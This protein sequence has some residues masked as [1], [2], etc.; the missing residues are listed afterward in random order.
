MIEGYPH[1]T[2]PMWRGEETFVELILFFHHRLQGVR[3]KSSGRLG[4]KH[5]LPEPS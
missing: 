1:A 3:V 4:S 2:A 5:L